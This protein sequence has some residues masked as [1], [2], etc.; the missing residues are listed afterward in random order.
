MKERKQTIVDYL[1]EQGYKEIP[2]VLDVETTSEN[3][4][5]KT[6]TLRLI[7]FNPNQII[8]GS[9]LNEFNFEL[10]IIYRYRETL[11]D[12]AAEWLR[13]NFGISQLFE[14]KGFESNSFEKTG[15]SGKAVGR[16]TFIFGFETC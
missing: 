2:N 4:S 9:S 13:V 8:G 5:H 1:T 14:F 10:A 16:S 7:G 15:T 11:D 6:Y 12:V 3:L